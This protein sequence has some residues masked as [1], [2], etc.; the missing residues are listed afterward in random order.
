[1]WLYHGA[2]S[3]TNV[4]RNDRGWACVQRK[5]LHWDHLTEKGIDDGE[6]QKGAEMFYEVGSSAKLSKDPSLGCALSHLPAFASSAGPTGQRTHPLRILNHIQ[7]FILQSFQKEN[8][9]C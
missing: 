8:W 2:Q 4:H 5:Q 9:K 3:D 6:A 7:Q 1:M